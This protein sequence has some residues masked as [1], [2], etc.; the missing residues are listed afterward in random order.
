MFVAGSV[1]PLGIAVFV[2]TSVGATA[3]VAVAAGAAVA[4]AV[5]V[6]TATGAEV[7]NTT[8]GGT[9]VGTGGGV[10]AGAHET[11]ISVAAIITNKSKEYFFI[12][13]SLRNNL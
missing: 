1:G 3:S 8:V 10:A 9:A 4:T 11:E 7:G 5:S 12:D 2:A 6:E 13:F